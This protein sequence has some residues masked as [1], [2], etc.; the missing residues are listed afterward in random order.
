MLK[1]IIIEDEKTARQS[2]INVLLNMDVNV[3]I[4]AQLSSV[5]E[6]VDYFLNAPEADLIFCDVQLEDGLSFEIF[7]KVE[8]RAPVIFI[9]GYDQFVMNAFE[10]NGIDYLL[11]PVSEH[12][13]QK[14]IVKYKKLEKH[15]N[16]QPSISNLVQYVNTRKKTRLIVKKGLE[17][18]SLR[19]EEIVLFFTENKIVYVVDKWGKK[20]LVDKN[21]GE[22][23]EDL[24]DSIFFRANRQYIINI[25]YIKGFKSYEKVKL[26]VDLAI[27]E[28]NYCI[29]ISQETAPAFRKWMHEA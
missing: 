13:L 6:S 8:I 1:T 10:Y 24:D 27:P 28:L 23:E 3:T 22:L 2:L 16:D 9:T 17:N 18:I 21:L 4:V 12:E 14:A 19:L 26:Q 29:I 5:R 15:F 11:K 7:S 25:N 20:Y